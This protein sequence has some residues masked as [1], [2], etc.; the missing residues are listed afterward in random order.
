MV[1]DFGPRVLEQRKKRGWSQSELAHRIEKSSSTISA[2]ESDTVMPSL[3]AASNLADVFG[4]SVDYLIQGNKSRSISAQ[5]LTDEQM[6]LA[7]ELVQELT[8]PTG[9]GPMMS[10]MQMRLLALLVAEFVK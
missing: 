4:V 3:E 7:V 6:Q 10:E 5:G 2:Y 1:Y 8:H 9:H